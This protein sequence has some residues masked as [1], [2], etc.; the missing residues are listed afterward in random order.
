MEKAR[1][2][3]KEVALSMVKPNPEM[4]VIALGMGMQSTALYLMSSM[5]E[6]ER[7]DYAVFSDPGAEH[8]DTYKLLD[9]LLDWKDKNNGIPLIINKKQNL[10]NDV[11]NQQN[12]YGGKWASIPA[13]SESGGMVRRQCTNDYKILPVIKSMREIYGLKKHKRMPLTEMWLGI[14]IDEAQR[15]KVNQNPRII[16]RYPFLELMMNRSDCRYFMEKNGFPIP[17]KSAC[18]FC[19]YH[20]NSM[21]KDMKKENDLAWEIILSVDK[22]IRDSSQRGESDKLYLHRSCKP[23]DEIDFDEN[24]IDM[25]DNECDGHC[26]L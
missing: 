13:F 21:W 10:L 3:L 14:T 5:G 17:V 8:K 15:M 4:K 11:L 25:F 26:G 24:Q 12:L 19:P 1:K 18:V 6:F 20:S 2:I 23:I 16:N 7:A 22:A 9:W